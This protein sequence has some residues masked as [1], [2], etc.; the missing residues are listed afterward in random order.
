MKT[1]AIT[2]RK[3]GVLLFYLY[4]I[5]DVREYFFF[6]KNQHWFSISYEKFEAAY[7]L[8]YNQVWTHFCLKWKQIDFNTLNK[9]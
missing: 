8:A 3:I 4:F 9:I 1:M 6:F 5:D 2:F 7:V